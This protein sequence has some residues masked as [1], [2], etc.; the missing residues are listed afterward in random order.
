MSRRLI[1]TRWRGEMNG[2]A[3][4]HFYFCFCTLRA[5]SQWAQSCSYQ[6][7]SLHFFFFSIANFRFKQH[8]KSGKHSNTAL[9]FTYSKI[10]SMRTLFTST[11]KMFMIKL[12]ELNW[13]LLQLL[14]MTNGWFLCCVLNFLLLKLT[15]Y[16]SRL[17][18]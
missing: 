6:Q 9:M 5:Q 15:T 8:I 13:Y 3:Q 12:T 10:A 2:A 4:H 11:K 7:F 14:M 1:E 18:P 16:F 17:I